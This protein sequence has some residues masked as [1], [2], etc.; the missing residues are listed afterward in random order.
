MIGKIIVFFIKMEIIFFIVCYF[1]NLVL[2]VFI[3][4]GIVGYKDNI[5]E[6]Y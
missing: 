1:I 4:L 2:Y 3:V 5:E 6:Y